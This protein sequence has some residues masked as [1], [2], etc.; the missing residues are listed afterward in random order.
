MKRAEETAQIICVGYGPPVDGCI[1]ASFI[2]GS[3][4]YFLLALPTY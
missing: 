3:Y 4:A 1:W 2:D